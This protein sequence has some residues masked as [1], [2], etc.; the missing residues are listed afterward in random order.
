[1]K[2]KKIQVTENDLSKLREAITQAENSGYRNS[3]YILQLKGELDRAKIVEPQ[4]ISADV[5]TMNSR[6][7]LIDLSNQ[8]KMELKLVF[9]EDSTKEETNVSV[10]APIGTAMIGYQTGDEFEWELPAGK[11]RLRVEKVLYQPEA[12]GIYD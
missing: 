8:E 2:K 9:P 4:K 12:S 1:M 3:P 7:I 10:L 11:T 5:I 6:V